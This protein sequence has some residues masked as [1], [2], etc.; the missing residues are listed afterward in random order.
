ME[1]IS[2]IQYDSVAIEATVWPAATT[3]KILLY[4]HGGGLIFGERN[5]LPVEYISKFTNKGY[6]LIML[7]YLLSPEVKIDKTLSVLKQSINKLSQFYNLKELT[8]MG[9]SAGAFLAYLL[10]RDGL[11]ADKFIDLYGYYKINVPEFRIPAPFYNRFPQVPPMT[12][13]LNVNEAPLVSGAMTKRYPIYV[14][15]RQFGTWLNQ[16]LPSISQIELYSLT[17]EQLKQMPKT[18]LIHCSDDPDIPFSIAKHA[19]DFIPDSKL[20]TV[21][22]SEHDFDRKVTAETLSY[23][24]QIVQFIAD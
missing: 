6:T 21:N 17:D 10:L 2:L 7:D 13:Q 20:M 1:T 16:F 15:G 18:I 24:D 23:Y 12:A 8:I 5:D 14:S 19:I 3:N 22:K 4:L 11:A 9:R